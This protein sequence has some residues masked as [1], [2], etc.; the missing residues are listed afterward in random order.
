MTTE[1]YDELADPYEVQNPLTVR[2]ETPAA[3]DACTIEGN[4][5]RDS[6]AARSLRCWPG[7]RAADYSVTQDDARFPVAKVLEAAEVASRD[8]E[9]SIPRL[10]EWM[11]DSDAAVRYWAAVG[12][13]VRG[14]KASPAIDLLRG[15]LDDPS[16]C[17]RIAAGEALVRV[18]QSVGLDRLVG[19]LDAPGGDT[20]AALDALASLGSRAK[21]ATEAIQS[22]IQKGL[23]GKGRANGGLIDLAAADLL[24]ILGAD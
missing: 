14:I 5:N 12:C 24:K 4:Q 19:E 2:A 7:P 22:R 11:K 1:L 13:S 8:D 6:I 23:G 3:R 16:P 9:P 10:I 15:L 20:L 17:T 18:N 21:P